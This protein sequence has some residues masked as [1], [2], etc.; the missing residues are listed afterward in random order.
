MSILSLCCFQVAMAIIGWWDFGFVQFASCLTISTCSTQ[1]WTKFCPIVLHYSCL[2][3]FGHI[4]CNQLDALGR[5]W[6]PSL[7][8][9]MPCPTNLNHLNKHMNMFSLWHVRWRR[10]L[11]C[12]NNLSNKG[13]TSLVLMW[14]GRGSKKP[15]ML[16]VLHHLKLD[17]NIRIIQQRD[18]YSCPP[19]WVDTSTAWQLAFGKP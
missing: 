3:L 1:P 2:H 14:V 9:M 4:T 18:I 8:Q 6:L 16:L 13:S 12:S 19:T 7:I 11:V 10:K 17:Y 15:I 5:W